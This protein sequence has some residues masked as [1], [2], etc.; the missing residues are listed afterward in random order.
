[1]PVY[2]HECQ[3]AQISGCVELASEI[4]QVYIDS[5]HYDMKSDWCLGVQVMTWNKVDACE[6]RSLRCV[7]AKCEIESTWF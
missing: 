4:T 3:I 5:L 7:L 2:Y 6:A 1:M